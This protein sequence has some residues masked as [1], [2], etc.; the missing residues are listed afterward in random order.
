[1]DMMALIQT[2]PNLGFALGLHGL[3]WHELGWHGLSFSSLIHFKLSFLQI[4]V[5]DWTVLAQQFETD[6]FRGIREWFANLVAT[7]QLWALIIG[8][9]IGYFFRAS[10]SYG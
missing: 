2:S 7:G 4:H 6:P 1:M 10:T 3:A 5:T 8:F 9:I